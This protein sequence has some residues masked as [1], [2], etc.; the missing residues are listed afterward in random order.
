MERNEALIVMGILVL[1]IIW[2]AMFIHKPGPGQTTTTITI[3][4]T[5][6]TMTTITPTTTSTVL[7]NMTTVLTTST[8]TIPEN[9]TTTTIRGPPYINFSYDE[10]DEISNSYERDSCY[11]NTAMRDKNL[12]ICQR[13]ENEGRRDICTSAIIMSIAVNNRDISKC[14]EIPLRV[15]RERCKKLIE[16]QR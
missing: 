13:I 2:G 12:S 11:H 5:I 9:V 6:T 7:P 14:D 8:S 10:C 15:I 1:I 4:T 16:I 3:P